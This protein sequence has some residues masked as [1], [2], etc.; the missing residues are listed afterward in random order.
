MFIQIIQKYYFLPVVFLAPMI[1]FSEGYREYIHY[2]YYN[3]EDISL[4]TFCCL[5]GAITG[6]LKGAFLGAT[7]PISLPIFIGRFIDK[8]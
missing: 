1:S 7:W 5:M 4:H 3:G 8:K 2:K 6:M